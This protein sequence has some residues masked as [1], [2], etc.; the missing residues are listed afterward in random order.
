MAN[1]QGCFVWGDATDADIPCSTN[2]RT[3]FRSTGGYYIYTNSGLTSGVYV[4]AGGGSWGSVSDR[5]RKENLQPVDTPAL[6]ENLAAIEISTWN[7]T[8]QNPTI[9]HIGPMAH[10]FNALLPDL[11]GEG[12]AYINSLDAD[13]VALA[14]IQELYAQNKALEAESA[15]LR[16][17]IRD[18][19]A[20]VERLEETAEAP[21]SSLSHRPAS[22]LVLGGLL[23]AALMVRQQR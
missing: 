19:E 21:A 5:A 8:S 11:G 17:Q 20:R 12:E 10:D 13:G 16:Q 14:A 18:L 1:N 4:S 7:Y 6:L 22:W 15:L 23:M 2:N 9:R 3:I